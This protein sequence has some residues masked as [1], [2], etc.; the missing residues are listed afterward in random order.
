MAPTRLERHWTMAR[1]PSDN[2][3]SEIVK[4][5]CTPDEKVELR[6]RAASAGVTLSK[7][8]LRCALPGTKA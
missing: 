4:A 3:A 1:P 2:P 7:Y 5:R 6:R 8:L